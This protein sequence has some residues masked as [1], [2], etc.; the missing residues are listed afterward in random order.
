[1]SVWETYKIGG[2]E[3]TPDDAVR[4]SVKIDG[5]EYIVSDR[6]KASLRDTI[7]D[8][9]EFKKFYEK[10]KDN[11]RLFEHVL[12]LMNIPDIKKLQEEFS[13]ANLLKKETL[14]IVKKIYELPLENHLI[15]LSSQYFLREPLSHAIQFVFLMIKRHFEEIVELFADCRGS[16]L[17]EQKLSQA[18]QDFEKLLQHWVDTNTQHDF[19]TS[20]VILFFLNP[21]EKSVN[22]ELEIEIK[23]LADETT[24]KS[25]KTLASAIKKF[26]YPGFCPKVPK[27]RLDKLLEF[28]LAEFVDAIRKLGCDKKLPDYS[29]VET[30]IAD[31]LAKA[32]VEKPVFKESNYTRAPPPKDLK[33]IPLISWYMDAILEMRKSLVPHA[34]KMEDYYTNQA[35]IF[36]EIGQYISRTLVVG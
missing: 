14:S 18:P 27:E 34:K 12:K 23:G 30:K 24:A 36:N 29:E 33:D 2:L 22:E 35:K 15:C 3:R 20:S 8:W 7:I 13:P 17:E 9:T 4:D 32:Q 25:L 10:T 21:P 5:V 11:E 28:P 19:D 16:F 31:I 6:F 26:K 1:M